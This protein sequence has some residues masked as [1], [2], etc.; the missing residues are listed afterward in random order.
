M[1]AY[2][3]KR[4]GA[5]TY[6]GR[7][8]LDGEKRI[9][10]VELGCSNRQVAD[11]KLGKIVEDQEREA[12]GIVAPKVQRDAARIPLTEHLEEMIASK[13]Q[14]NDGHYL[15]NMKNRVV[16]L[17]SECGWKYPKDVSPES[18]QTW[19]GARNLS[20][21][22]LN[23]YLISARTLF[24]WMEK[25]GRIMVNP[26]KAVDLLSTAGETRNPRRALAHEEFARL[27]DGSGEA[28][29]AYLVTA[30]T[31]LRY[32]EILRIEV[33]DVRLDE[34]QPRII[35]RAMAKKKNKKEASLPLHPAVVAR[36]R[37]FLDS[38]QSLPG[39]KPFVPLFRKRGQFKRDLEAAGIPRHDQRGRIADFHSLR[40]TFCTNLQRLGTPQRVLMHLMRHSDRKLSDYLYTDTSMLPANESVR[41][42]FVPGA[43]LS[44]I[45][46]QNLVPAGQTL[47][48]SVAMNGANGSSNSLI[49]S[50]FAH[51][52][53]LLVTTSHNCEN[54]RDAG[55]EPVTPTVSRRIPAEGER[56]FLGSPLA[57]GDGA[58]GSCA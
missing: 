39:D 6:S 50:S 21:K 30:T 13:A 40:H 44:Q 43:K 51:G 17:I 5:R 57:E 11:K 3:F 4:R 2:V 36:L 1:I 28:G 18:F 56:A 27:V 54:M 8:R 9:T 19:V 10:Q 34:P 37:A 7:Y 16:R 46:S 35:A 32:S 26:L 41:K 15:S 33:R 20:A 14:A 23:E 38:R 24:N 29:V 55:F 53:A 12:A 52:Q 42:L 58:G 47:S 31:G 45:P 22:A 49:T 25:R 48:Q